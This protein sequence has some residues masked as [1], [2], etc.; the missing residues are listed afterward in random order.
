M[1]NLDSCC[2]GLQSDELELV[3]LCSAGDENNTAFI[4]DGWRLG[5]KLPGRGRAL[6]DPR[7]LSGACSS[8]RFTREWNGAGVLQKQ[9]IQALDA[10]RLKQHV[11]FDGD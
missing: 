2:Y 7:W 3:D 5:G 11:T 4:D 1:G 9:K 8:Y 10:L 6:Q